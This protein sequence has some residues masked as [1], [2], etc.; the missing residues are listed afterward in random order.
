MFEEE[1]KKQLG[2]Y[3]TNGIEC[4][5]MKDYSP[6]V[7]VIKS[8]VVF[9]QWRDDYDYEQAGLIRFGIITEEGEDAIETFSVFH[10]IGENGEELWEEWEIEYFDLKFLPVDE[11]M[12][13][14][15]L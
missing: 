8:D 5:N 7:E 6:S 9:A 15:N 3:N 14:I 2:W 1:E 4:F 10:G 11:L 13:K 12:K